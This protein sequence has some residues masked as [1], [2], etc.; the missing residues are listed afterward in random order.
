MSINKCEKYIAGLRERETK[1]KHR[2]E[3]SFICERHFTSHFPRQEIVFYLLSSWSNERK[4]EAC[5]EK[6]TNHT[7]LNS[8]IC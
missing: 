5:A 3:S 2:I 6:R 8:Q 1:V 7:Q 4:L